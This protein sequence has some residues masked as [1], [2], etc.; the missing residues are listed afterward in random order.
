MR[1]SQDDEDAVNE[2][3]ISLSKK[4]KIS[5]VA[6]NNTYYTEKSQ[7]NA[8][9]ILLCVKDGEK[10]ITPIGR[11]RGFRYG[12]MNQ[13][14]YFKSQEEMKKLFF[15]IP[16]AVDSIEEI[17]DKIQFYDLSREV[18]LPKFI[19]PKSFTKFVNEDDK[20]RENK[21][22][23]FLTFEG[24]KKRYKNVSNEIIP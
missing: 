17:I 24:A 5:L 6:T 13:E 11:G 1:H 3:L 8:H 16:E 19:N 10:Q 18:L 14:Y 15:D 4:H 20:I 23:E 2:S 22:L 9:D 21:Y 7:A 12:L